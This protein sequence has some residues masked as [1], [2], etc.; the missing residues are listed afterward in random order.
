MNEE[1]DIQEENE[2]NKNILPQKAVAA[3]ETNN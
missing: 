3:N 1:Q 2:I